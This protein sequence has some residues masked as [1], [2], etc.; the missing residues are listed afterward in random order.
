VHQTVGIV[1]VLQ[2]EQM[3][4]FVQCNLGRPCVKEILGGRGTIQ[5]LLQSVEG[6]ERDS[7]PQSG[8]SE[9]M[10]EYGHKNIDRQYGHNFQIPVQGQGFDGLK[11]GAGVVLQTLMVKSTGRVL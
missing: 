4:Q 6:N 11:Y 7:A 8:L 5:V 10:S 1:T 9:C 3:P 2:V